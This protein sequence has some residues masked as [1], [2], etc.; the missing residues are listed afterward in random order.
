[1]S[2]H[3][4]IRASGLG[5]AFG[6]AI[7]LIGSC[8]VLPDESDTLRIERLEETVLPMARVALESE[9]TETARRLYQRLLDIDPDSVNARMGL[10]D[11]A[12]AGRDPAEAA[13]WYGAA[14]AHARQADDLQVA[15]LAHGRA[16]LAAGELNAAR[17]SFSRL[18][19]ERAQAPTLTVAWGHNGLGL[20]ALLEG[21][22]RGAVKF[23]EQAALLAPDEKMLTD[24][25]SR[26][27]DLSAG[28]AVEGAGDDRM[29]D[30]M[31]DMAVAAA[32]ASMDDIQTP[33]RTD[34]DAR[35]DDAMNEVAAHRTPAEPTPAAG[36]TREAD[37]REQ[38]PAD[39]GRG[40]DR[41][42][43]ES[44]GIDDRRMES[45]GTESRRIES[46]QIERSE[47]RPY[48]VKVDGDFYVRIGAHTR[49]DEARDVAVEL[50]GVTTETVEVVE[51]GRGDGADAV[52]L[53]RV[54]VGPIKSSAALVELVAT[55]EEMGYGAARVP[56]SIAAEAERA[57]S[58]YPRPRRSTGR[59]PAGPDLV[60]ESLRP[61]GEESSAPEVGETQ[62]GQA[63]NGVGA[64]ESGNDAG[65]DAQ[66]RGSDAEVSRIDVGESGVGA[67]APGADTEA[68][69]AAADDSDRMRSLDDGGSEDDAASPT[70]PMAEVPVPAAVE[71][72]QDP[73]RA[74]PDAA[75]DGDSSLG[76]DDV[77][78]QGAETPADA[79]QF[80]QVGAYAI[81][82]AAQTVAA[83][84]G[85]VARAPV[86]VIEAEMPN[87]GTIYRVQVGP[88]ASQQ[89]MQ[90]L[91]E[92][93]IS[94]GYGTVR[95]L[96]AQ[97]TTDAVPGEALAVPAPG[98]SGESDRRVKAFIVYED[99]ERFLQM[100]AYAVRA[101]AETLAAQLRLV[102]SEPVSA[103]EA[104]DGGGAPLYRVRIGPIGS[105]AAFE[106][107]L[108][109][110]RPGYGTGWVLPSMD[111]ESTGAAFIVHENSERFLQVGAYEDL[112]AAM[113]LASRLR[114]QIDG[115]IRVTD[116]SFGGGDTI[117]RV[118]I[119][120]LASHASLLALVESVESLGYVVD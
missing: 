114:G 46:R 61:P 42:R 33:A 20:V 54:M 62:A 6:A 86:R 82:S 32:V 111:T 8:S 40:P 118:R 117:Y 66:A 53:F 48:V 50:R 4:L 85:G 100:G 80:L 120:P 93:L 97:A 31:Q 17:R 113:A 13:L 7:S 27:L 83:E 91:G 99:G 79:P 72:A 2:C 30:R 68:S 47:L 109:A 11:I 105:D 57:A 89:E 18:T 25:L 76:G 55:L 119:G 74:E 98:P 95:V 84:V 39:A 49:S 44:G 104:P 94:G 35:D 103:V 19:S 29:Q 70:V 64:Q 3:A 71:E 73:E 69:G 1:M 58:P 12:L 22:I 14:V 116:V 21:D 34:G 41:N 108:R 63:T 36:S 37:A 110:L 43:M 28:M 77:D 102:A 5:L 24:N 45:G 23:M 51:F 106:R 52:R 9:Q 112:A 90:E 56:P 88:I 26:V 60:E 10:G 75:A 87:G 115:D 65:D 81:R 38:R 92:M 78:G 107:L 15:L 16:A 67:E 59:R 96:P 101:T